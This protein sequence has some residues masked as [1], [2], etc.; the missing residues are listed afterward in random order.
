MR[1][2]VSTMHRLDKVHV[3]RNFIQKVDF[4]NSKFSNYQ[5]EVSWFTGKWNV[6]RLANAV[7]TH[8]A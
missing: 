3:E 2:S 5:G 8:P 1:D 4:C 6:P 7:V